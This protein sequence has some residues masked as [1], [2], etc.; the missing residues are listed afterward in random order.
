[1]RLF[2]CVS[3]LI[4]LVLLLTSCGSDVRLRS[5]EAR[6]WFF[7]VG[8]ADCALIRTANVTIVVDAGISSDVDGE[9]VVKKLRRAGVKQLD[10]LV[11]T[12][13]HSD[14]IG[15]AVAIMD[16]FAVSACLLPE[17]V[18]DSTL[19]RD[20]MCA[21]QEEECRV[22]KA[23]RGVSLTVG[24]FVVDVLSPPERHNEG[25]NADSAVLRIAFG[26]AVALFMGDASAQIEGALLSLYGDELKADILKVSHH[27]SKNSSISSFLRTVSPTYAV[28]ACGAG[29]IYGFPAAEVL[30]RLDEINA[31]VCRTDTDGTIAFKM[32]KNGDVFQK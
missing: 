21:L 28:I 13:P 14:H 25:L 20:V 2:R 31:S 12:H 24:D 32:L 19:F 9:D 22:L 29:N 16:A 8:Q 15:A 26:D 3:F 10:M 5:D 30:A 18:E 11:L 1:M 23:E 27:G 6:L 4:V 17:L 7:D